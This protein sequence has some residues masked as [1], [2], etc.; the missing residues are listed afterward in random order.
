MTKKKWKA[1]LFNML[2]FVIIYSAA[3]FLIINF[4]EMLG[5]WIP[6]TSAIVAMILAPKFQVATYQGE[7]KLFM[8]SM[9]TKGV[10]EIK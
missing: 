6:L 9:F 8:K 5:Y 3:Y 2:G 10:K 1:L 7:E 4:T